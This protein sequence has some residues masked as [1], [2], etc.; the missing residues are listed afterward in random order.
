MWNEKG[1]CRNGDQC[2]FAH[3]F[4]ELRAREQSDRALAAAAQGKGAGAVPP[5]QQWARGASGAQRRG[6]KTIPGEMQYTDSGAPGNFES[7]EYA[8][9]SA[10]YSKHPGVLP[11]VPMMTTM[12]K[13]GAAPPGGAGGADR[14]DWEPMFVQPLPSVPLPP[15][16]VAGML[17]PPMP[18]VAHQRLAVLEQY[19][20]LNYV[21]AQTEQLREWENEIRAS[22]QEIV[23]VSAY[24][25]KL[26]VAQQRTEK[27][28][29]EVR[30]Y[31]DDLDSDLDAMER[32]VDDLFS[33]SAVRPPLDADVEREHA[34]DLSVRLETQLG[35]MLDQLK[36]VVGT[37]NGAHEQQAGDEK[38]R[39]IMKI[40]NAHHQS[41]AYLSSQAVKVEAEVVKLERANETERRAQAAV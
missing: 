5:S 6:G 15:S 36:D 35:G 20:Q 37:L 9:A 26:V 4:D 21:T 28:L 39:D 34:Y 11:N 14:H 10:L 38:N 2:R 29:G 33:R 27:V 41:L 24:A 8:M 18:Q 13:K 22:Q 19:E 17:Q 32:H 40:V 31:Q 3:G 7:L 1:R 23:E 25:E 16:S 12:G 30:A